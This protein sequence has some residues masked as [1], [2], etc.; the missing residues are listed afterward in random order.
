[1]VPGACHD[2]SPFGTP[3]ASGAPALSCAD[4]M[5]MMLTTCDSDAGD[6]HQCRGCNPVYSGVLV[7]D[8]CRVVCD[9]CAPQGGH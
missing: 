1:V 6:V 8:M 7:R 9:N 4:M 2:A 3:D 5:V